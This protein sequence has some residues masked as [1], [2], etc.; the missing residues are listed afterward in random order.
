MTK[1]DL[2]IIIEITDNENVEI[3]TAYPFSEQRRLREREN[4]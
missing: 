1:H 4:R 2:Y 3:V